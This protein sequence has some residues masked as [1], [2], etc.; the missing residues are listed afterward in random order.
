M[1]NA[2]AEHSRFGPVGWFT[3]GTPEWRENLQTITGP[4]KPNDERMTRAKADHETCSYCGSITPQYF[5]ELCKRPEVVM[6]VAD[7]KYGW[8]HKVYID[9]PGGAHFKFYTIHMIDL[10]DLE[11]HSALVKSRTDVE[12]FKNPEGK[13]MWKAAPR[14]WY[15]GS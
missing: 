2:H 6:E 10:E 1:T 13:I 5:V 11:A 9:V 3:S 7:W 12:F 8:P 4:L 15:D 14:G